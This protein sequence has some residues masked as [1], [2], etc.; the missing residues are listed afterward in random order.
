MHPYEYF[1]AEVVS[2]LN[3]HEQERLMNCEKKAMN[4]K[5][6]AYFFYKHP[7][8]SSDYKRQIMTSMLRFY[9]H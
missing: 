1:Y 7:K 2:G 4:Y 9:Y 3:S 6:I 5:A 8:L